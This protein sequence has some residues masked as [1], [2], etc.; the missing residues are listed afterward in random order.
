M[1]DYVQTVFHSYPEVLV[2]MPR[3]APYEN[4]YSNWVR[5]IEGMIRYGHSGSTRF[6]HRFQARQ[7]GR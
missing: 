2:G 7:D 6:I 1:D 5:E 4:A 3:I